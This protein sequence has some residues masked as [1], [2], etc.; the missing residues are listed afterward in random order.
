M[1][2]S[3]YIIGAGA[4]GKTL[5]V[6]LK[7]NNKRVVLVRGTVDEI[8]QYCEKITVLLNDNSELEA[9]IE[10]T[11]LSNLT[12]LN[13]IILLTNKSYGN[14]D[15]ARKLKDKVGHS[16][17]VL[18]QNGLGVEQPFL[19]NEFPEIYRCVLFAT[20]QNITESKISYKP[21]SVSP[22]GEVSR[23]QT[24]LKYIIDLIDSADFK[25][26]AEGNIQIIA[27]KKAIINCVF[28]SVCP[29]LEID[30]GIFH[31]DEMAL[32]IGKAVI[33][34]CIG[35]ANEIGIA[36][37]ASEIEEQLLMISKRSDGQFISTYHDIK[38]NR[39]T[40]IDTLNFEVVRIAKETGRDDQV[41]IT[42]VLGELIKM[43][44]ALSGNTS[45]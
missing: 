4:I 30:N 38:N 18:L 39:R 23:Q 36:L 17:I 40:E 37:D 32:D 20:C 11:S 7:R 15:L 45:I 12:R 42:K 24:Y 13:G 41:P 31:R 33:R 14:D 43:K 34:E 1:E 9:E 21:V 25:F 5:A 3:I 35:V 22:V 26:K 8:V 6:F 19:R 10:V 27:W 2:S 44:S 28:N 16:P 29:L